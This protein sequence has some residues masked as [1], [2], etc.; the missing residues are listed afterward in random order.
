MVLDVRCIEPTG[1][2]RLAYCNE[3]AAR[4]EYPEKIFQN[5]R[6]DLTKCEPVKAHSCVAAWAKGCDALTGK[7][8]I[9]AI[10]PVQW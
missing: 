2:W 4:G 7:A 8:E 3:G 10:D 6:W 5:D 1:G 9:L